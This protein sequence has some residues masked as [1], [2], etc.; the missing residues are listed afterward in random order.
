MEQVERLAQ[1]HGFSVDSVR[2]LQDAV[3]RGGGRMAQFSPPELGG[4]GQWSAGGI[5]QIGAMND[6]GLRD[7]VGRLC[8][9]LAAE[10]AP[11][12]TPPVEPSFGRSA[13]WWP[14]DLGRPSAAG[15]QN[16]MRY[17]CFPEAK[18]VAVE[19][20]GRV[21]VYDSGQ[22]RI[23]GVSQ[24]QGGGQELVFS[25]QLGEVRAQDLPVA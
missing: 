1:E 15:T 4:M 10:P 22:H 25:S 5:T 23:S 17:A 13:D 21:T 2:V 11:A 24:S 12:P 19:Q 3:T 20:A 9:A 16:G 6:N 7:R 14:G 18:R 8:A